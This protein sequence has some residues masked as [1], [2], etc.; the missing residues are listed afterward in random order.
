QS[1]GQ[2]L[3]AG[4]SRAGELDCGNV[5][6]DKR[7]GPPVAIDPDVGLVPGRA[8]ERFGLSLYLDSD[9][10]ARLELVSL[11]ALGLGR[12][13]EDVVVAELNLLR[14]VILALSR[15][16]RPGPRYSRGTGLRCQ[17]PAK[18]QKGDNRRQNRSSPKSSVPH[19]C[20]SV[21]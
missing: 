17:A 2:P 1:R 13:Q 5:D 6:G 19:G 18:D 11:Q 16:W 3:P 12:I 20:S 9:V 4:R 15:L 14:P 10:A 21:N 7:H 8:V